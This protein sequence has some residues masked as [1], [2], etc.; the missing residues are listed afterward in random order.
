MTIS[1]LKCRL[2]DPMPR[3]ARRKETAVPPN[4]RLRVMARP[5]TLARSAYASWAAP[6]S[7]GT[8]VRAAVAASSTRTLN[9]R[10]VR[11]AVG[12]PA[13][14]G[15]RCGRRSAVGGISLLVGYLSADPGGTRSRLQL[16]SQRSVVE[17]RRM[18][19]VG[20]K[21]LPECARREHV[22]SS[23]LDSQI[24]LCAVAQ[25]IHLLVVSQRAGTNPLDAGVH[26]HGSGACIPA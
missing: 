17:V 14:G 1:T 3:I 2:P 22:R 11:N 6:T 10:D 9:R 23:T 5:S 20:R 15:A 16:D 25:P 18:H 26:V 21:S 8:P 12:T 19:H 7:T 24:G 13:L 4:R